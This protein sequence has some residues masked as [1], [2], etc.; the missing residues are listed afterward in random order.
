VE[1]NVD[2]LAVSEHPADGFLPER[3]FY[4][5]PADSIEE[6]GQ[7]IGDS[8]INFALFLAMNANGVDDGTVVQ[9]AKKLLSKGLASLCTWGPDCERVHDLFDF[10]AR[11]IESKLPGDDVVVTTWHSDET[12]E[13]ALWYFA[14]ASFVTDNFVK[15]C[16]DW[17]ISPIS[18]PEWEQQIRAKI[19]RIDSS[20]ED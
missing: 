9:G 11:D 1:S 5:C 4:L 19:A 10:A 13:E 8:S 18:N 17:I 20:T 6:L 7:K 3:V 14:R 15:T 16:K 12:M 2:R